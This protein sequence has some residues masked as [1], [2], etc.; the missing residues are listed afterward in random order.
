MSRAE[1]DVLRTAH[2]PPARLLTG[3]ESAFGALSDTDGRPKLMI[4]V[5]LG[6]IQANA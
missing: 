2:S 1:L 4:V 5:T 6:D 3:T